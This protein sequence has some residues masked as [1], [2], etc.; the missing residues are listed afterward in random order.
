MNFLSVLEKLEAF[1]RDRGY[2]CAL[3]GGLSMA[4][5]GMP[6]TTLDLDV[7]VPGEA[8]EELVA[9]LENEGYETLYRSEGYSNH[10]HGDSEKGRVDVVYVRGETSRRLFE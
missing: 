8:Q 3:I 4:A 7:V 1:L 6:R 9:F 5:Y 10:L 2:P